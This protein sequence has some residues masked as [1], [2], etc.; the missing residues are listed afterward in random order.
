MIRI[1]AHVETTGGIFNAPANARRLRARAFALF[2]TNPRTWNSPPLEL[3]VIDRFWKAM[4]KQGYSPDHVVPHDNYLIN[5]GNPDKEKLKKSYSAFLEEMKRCEQLGLMYLNTHPGS[6]LSETGEEKCLKRIAGCI[7][8]ALDATNGVTILLENTAGQ[9]SSVG[10][11]FEHLAA[12]IDMTEDT[13]RI[14]ICYDTCHGNAAGYDI[15]TK[16]AY[17][18]T[19]KDLDTIIGLEY[20]KAMHFNDARSGF[21]SRVDR[22]ESLGKGTIGLDPFCFLVN[23]PRLDEIPMILETARKSLW[24]KEIAMLYRFI[25]RAGKNKATAARKSR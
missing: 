12:I 15:R 2:L 14:G 25:K 22:H 23:D 16:K 10:Y 24:K 21:G 11:A 18:K 1:G 13:S 19:M 4:E 6:R 9:G 20:L 8:R 17:E 3:S 7:N 5:L